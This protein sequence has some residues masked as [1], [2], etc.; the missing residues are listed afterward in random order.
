MGDD[1]RANTSSPMSQYP[2]HCSEHADQNRP[3]EALIGVNGTE[4][5]GGKDNARGNVL[6]QGDELPLQ[7]TTE[8]RLL[9]NARRDR[10]TD[11]Q[12]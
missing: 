9:A 11:P 8:N 4:R 10:E 7:V 3:P 12:C 5:S 1:S 2:K 6:S